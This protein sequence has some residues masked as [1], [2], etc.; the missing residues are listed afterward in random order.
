MVEQ[1]QGLFTLSEWFLFIRG[2]TS[3]WGHDLIIFRILI[4]HNKT[5]CI[6]QMSE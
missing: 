5:N 1:P 3:F 6:L 2:D 4:N